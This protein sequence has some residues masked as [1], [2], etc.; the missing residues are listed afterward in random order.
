MLN[1]EAAADEF[2]LESFKQAHFAGRWRNGVMVYN[3]R[4][5]AA[6]SEARFVTL[7]LEGSIPSAGFSGLSTEPFWYLTRHIDLIH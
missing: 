7:C 6:W 3:E 5:P 4:Q 2:N 1:D